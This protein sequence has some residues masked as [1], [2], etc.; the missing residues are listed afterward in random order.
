ML[1]LAFSFVMFVITHSLCYTLTGTLIKTIVN[2]HVNAMHECKRG[3]KDYPLL[4][5]CW[6]I[7]L[8]PAMVRKSEGP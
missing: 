3:P 7:F 5:G 8:F 2:M 1:T 6:K 4:N